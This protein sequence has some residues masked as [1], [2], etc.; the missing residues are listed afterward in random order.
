MM[1]ESRAL[2]PEGKAIG[3]ESLNPITDT[4]LYKVEFVNGAIETIPANVIAEN[5]LSQVDQ[6][7]HRQLLLDEIIS[8]RRLESAILRSEGTFVSSSGFTRRK[9]TTRGWSYVS[10]GR[11]VPSTGY[12]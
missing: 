12:H 6:E 1:V 11:T 5:L 9:Q 2:E 4:R 3:K 8:H 10:N 7:G